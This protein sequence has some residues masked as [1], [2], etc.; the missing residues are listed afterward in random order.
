MNSATGGFFGKKNSGKAFD[1]SKFQ[2]Y[3]VQLS[4]RSSVVID[5]LARCGVRAVPLNTE[6]LIE[7]YYGLYNPGEAEKGGAPELLSQ[8]QQG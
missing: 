7:L 5:G 3:Q 8:E 6:E 4:Q 1:E 2:E